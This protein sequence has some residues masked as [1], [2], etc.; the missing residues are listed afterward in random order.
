MSSVMQSPTA[1]LCPAQDVIHPFIQS[2]HTIYYPLAD[3]AVGSTAE[4]A[5]CLSA[6]KP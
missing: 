1:L 3:S 6:S 2:I 4:T 5:H